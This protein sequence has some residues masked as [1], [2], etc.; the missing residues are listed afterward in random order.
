MSDIQ[1][2]YK[3]KKRSLP[4][5]PHFDTSLKMLDYDVLTNSGDSELEF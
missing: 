5:V 1:K 4:Q 3:H 2:V